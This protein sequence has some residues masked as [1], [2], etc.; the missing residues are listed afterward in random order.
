VLLFEIISHITNL[1]S[2]DETLTFTYGSQTVTVTHLNNPPY[3]DPY[4]SPEV[5]QR[6]IMDTTILI[7]E[8]PG[9][10]TLVVKDDDGGTTITTI[11]LN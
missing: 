7:Y 3:S 8:G 4:P 2:D 9:T 5:N 10:I 11:D 6:D 1:G